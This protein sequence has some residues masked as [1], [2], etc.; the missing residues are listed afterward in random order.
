MCVVASTVQFVCA[1]V[2]V[3][4]SAVQS[5]CVVVSAWLC[6]CVRGVCDMRCVCVLW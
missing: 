6:V 1:V 2:C 3:V 4:A 5:V